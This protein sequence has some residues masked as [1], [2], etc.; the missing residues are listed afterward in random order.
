MRARLNPRW[1]GRLSTSIAPWR[2]S[3]HSTAKFSSSPVRGTFPGE[4]SERLG[5]PLGTV[6]WTRQALSRWR[7]SFPRNGCEEHRAGPGCAGAW[8]ARSTPRTGR[9]RPIS[10][11]SPSAGEIRHLVA[12]TPAVDPRRP[13]AEARVMV[14]VEA[15]A[16]RSFRRGPALHRGRA[17][18]RRTPQGLAMAAALIAVVGVLDGG[19]Q[20]LKKQLADTRAALEHRQPASEERGGPRCPWHRCGLVDRADPG[21]ASKLAARITYDPVSR[22]G[23]RLHNPRPRWT[24]LRARYSLPAREPGVIHADASGRRWCSFRRRRPRNADLRRVLEARARPP[25]SSRRPVVMLGRI[26]G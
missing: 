10:P 20:E 16:K 1:T 17:A 8:S 9:S 23:G 4:I 21:R 26:R 18:P 12:R 7:S 6:S 15:D 11:K 22:R 14:A 2:S 3:S 19:N 5:A 13:A 25:D 24:R